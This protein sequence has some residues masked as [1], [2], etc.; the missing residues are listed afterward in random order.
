MFLRMRAASLAIL[1]TALAA[2]AGAAQ[3]PNA[4]PS[5]AAAQEAPMQWRSGLSEINEN[6]LQHEGDNL[7]WAQPAV[8]ESGW[9]A[10]DDVEDMG[11]A[12]TGW[13]WYRKHLNVGPDHSTVRLLVSAGDGTYELYVNGRRVEGAA[14]LS[15][16]RATR[17]KERVFE[18]ENDQGEFDIA[19][20]TFITPAYS[21]HRLPLFL[22]ITMGGPT[23][24]R[25]EHQALERERLYEMVPSAAINL[26]VTLGG[27]WTLALFFSQRGREY[28]FLGLYLALY[29]LSNGFWIAQRTGVLPISVNALFADPLVFLFTIAQIE[30]TFSFTRRK[31]YR[32]LRVY[33]VLLLLPLLLVVPCW[34]GHFYPDA[35][36]LIEA[37]IVAPV[38]IMLP[39]FLLAWYLRGNREAGLLILPSLLPSAVASLYNLGTFSIYLGWGNLGFLDNSIYLGPIPLNPSDLA[40]LLFLFAIGVV[41]AYRFTRV[42]REQARA[43]AELEAA[44]EIQQR[45]VPAVLPAVPGYAIEAAY[46]PAQEVGGDFYQVLPQPDGAVLVLVGDVSGKGLKAAMTGALTIGAVRTLSAEGLEPAK[47]LAR[48]NQQLTQ[49]QEGGFVTCL[50]AR[51]EAEG[52]VT[53]ANAGHLAPY[54]NR[55]EIAIEPGLPLGIAPDAEYLETTVQLGPAETLMFLS[56]GV[57]EARDASGELFGFDRTRSAS[58]GTAQSIAETA[59]RFGQEDDITVLSLTLEPSHVL[60]A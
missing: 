12:Q 19:F 58:S 57:V 24:I 1:F 22:Y 14:I 28:L 34:T 36:I 10:V 33:E 49:A 60:S 45:L 15:S 5:A 7:A 9:K 38:A 41:M 17:P 16:L 39:V 35:Y 51:I 53:L 59:Q 44:R 50:C 4:P 21:E 52:R 26:L 20:R 8:D 40:G 42:S 2:P 55:E 6:W 47:L 29:G 54:R 27:L 56:D 48:L 32:W 43:A 46:L 31:V 37:A 30:F 18:L 3:A 23:A 11:P 25:Y 13:R